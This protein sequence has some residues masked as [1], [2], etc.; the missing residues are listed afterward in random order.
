MKRLVWVLCA[1]GCGQAS[2]A[3]RLLCQGTVTTPDGSR[4][5]ASRV[6]DLDTGTGAVSVSTFHG[7]AEGIVK[8]SA[9]S[10]IGTI[11]AADGTGY[12]FTL[13]RYSGNLLLTPTPD[14]TKATKFF[15]EFYGS[16]NRATPKF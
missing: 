3:D 11:P 14:L 4:G 1:L 12:S 2:A 13:D 15:A 6:L 16:C 9:E 7:Q 8:Q 10:Y 5:D